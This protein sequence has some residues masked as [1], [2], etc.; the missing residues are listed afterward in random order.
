MSR[1]RKPPERLSPREGQIIAMLAEGLIYK[2]IA[3]H[4]HIRESSVKQYMCLARQRTGATTPQLVGRASAAKGCNGCP[5]YGAVRWAQH[6]LNAALTEHSP[7]Q[8][9]IHAV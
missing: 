1:M 3:A 2:Q 9:G 6:L 5:F 4:L 8:R 7:I